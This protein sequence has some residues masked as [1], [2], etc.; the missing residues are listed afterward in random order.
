MNQ[1]L[2][3]QALNYQNDANM[4]ECDYSECLGLAALGM[5]QSMKRQKA[6]KIKQNNTKNHRAGDWVCLLCNNLNYSFRNVCNRCQIQ[7]KKQNL[8]Q[9]LM[10]LNDQN[11]NINNMQISNNNAAHRKPF[12]DITNQFASNQMWG[13]INNDNNSNHRVN[14]PN[15]AH[16]QH[17]QAQMIINNS[18]FAGNLNIEQL[19][20]NKSKNS[21]K[22]SSPHQTYCELP[23]ENIS[24][25]QQHHA[26]QIQLQACQK[27]QQQGCHFG[28]NIGQGMNMNS[29]MDLTNI[30]M[31][32]EFMSNNI[33]KNKQNGFDLNST[34]TTCQSNGSEKGEHS[35]YNQMSGKMC[36]GFNTAIFLNECLI[37]PKKS[38]D[39]ELYQP[40]KSP[41]QV[42]Q[43]SHLLQ[44]IIDSDIKPAS[45]NEMSKIS[46]ANNLTSNFIYNLKIY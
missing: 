23:Y 18:N 22:N 32:D 9:A 45:D 42:P 29:D 20:Q 39:W 5:D 7:S 27:L 13:I 40:Y 41:V 33:M 11:S 17:H 16:G 36:Q 10:L 6:K 35:N 21:S 14:K 44:K 37:T 30:L 12:N 8:L 38:K 15:A 1:E 24:P 46:S 43:I 28:S 31:N 2:N 19:V 25:L 34:L 4:S 3:A 26:S